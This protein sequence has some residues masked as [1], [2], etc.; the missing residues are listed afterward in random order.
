M[1]NI[2]FAW[3][4]YA[5]LQKKNQQSEHLND[6]TWGVE[7]ALN[8]LLTAI[9]TGNIPST[10]AELDAALDRV[11]SSGGRL[12]RSRATILKKFADEIQPAAT[13][14]PAEANLELAEIGRLF[15]GSEARILFDAGAGFND[16]EIGHR[17]SST[18]GAVRVR[19]SRLRRKAREILRPTRGPIRRRVIQ[20]KN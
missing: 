8:W 11:I 13:N 16:I 14:N 7:A 15:P 9:E 20:L 10:P 3:A 2:D 19:L 12:R 1:S 5:D 17:C 4:R 6:H 18:P